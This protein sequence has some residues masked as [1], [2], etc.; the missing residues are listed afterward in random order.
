MEITRDH[1]KE[2]PDFDKLSDSLTPAEAFAV[3]ENASADQESDL[4][5]SAPQDFMT[6]ERVGEQQPEC[7][8]SPQVFLKEEAAAKVEFQTSHVVIKEEAAV[9]KEEISQGLVSN[10]M[11]EDASLR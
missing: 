5:S 6:K 7:E 9:V 8:P 10:N 4:Q 11:P 1:L 2:E 3:E